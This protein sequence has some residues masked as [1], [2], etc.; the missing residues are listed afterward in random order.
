MGEMC[1]VRCFVERTGQIANCQ[2][3]QIQQATRVSQGFGGGA[4][5]CPE[6]FSDDGELALSASREGSISELVEQSLT[7]DVEQ[8]CRYVNHRFEGSVSS[9]RRR[10]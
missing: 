5:V 10:W 6:L 4:E 1:K 3:V 8:S 9:G 2:Q 7:I